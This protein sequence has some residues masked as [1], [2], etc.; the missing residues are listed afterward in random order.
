[1]L[2]YVED[3]LN[4]SNTA[5]F[6]GDTLFIGTTALLSS[7]STIIYDTNITTLLAG[8]G[9]FFEGTAQQM[10]EALL[11]VI[12]S[13]PLTTEVYCGHEYTVKNLQFA[14]T[15]E[16]NNQ[17]IKVRVILLYDKRNIGA[18]MPDLTG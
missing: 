3:K 4:S 18:N 16:S 5:V 9:R 6:T 13:L 1:M 7:T 14:H 11:G 17:H 2:Y 12:A 10:H 8:C 15:L